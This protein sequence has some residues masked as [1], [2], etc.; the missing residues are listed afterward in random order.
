[1]SA[2]KG[3]REL[4]LDL[5]G[6]ILTSVRDLLAS[7][8]A[9]PLVPSCIDH[10]ADEA[11]VYALYKAKDDSLLYIG[12]AEGS[13]GLKDRLLRH[14][15]KLNGRENI[16]P[17]TVRFRAVRLYV[18][19]AMDLESALIAA[20]GGVKRV[21]WNNSGFGSND[22]GKER[23]T[24]TYKAGHFDTDYP[25]RLDAA[26]VPFT[27]GEYL[28]SE[29][30]QSLKDGLPYLLR[31]ERPAASSRNSFH[32]DFLSARVTVTQADMPTRELV[33]MCVSAL[34]RGWHATA[35]PSHIICYK[36]DT[37]KYPSGVRI[38]ES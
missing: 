14:M 24:T 5:A 31:F 21:P 15:R 10:V 2:A 3:Y 12:K 37:R 17:S 27:P 36:N 38:A 33:R 26:F 4:E 28:V 25:I 23:D 18:F 20:Y 7:M 16:S 22:P 34:P 13:K 29:V 9:A 11:G 35:L 30:M 19:A 6:A 32:P 1:M 8:E